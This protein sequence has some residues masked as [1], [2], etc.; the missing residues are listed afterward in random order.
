MS[1]RRPY[2]TE[3]I[4]SIKSQGLDP[5]EL[6]ITLTQSKAVQLA[7]VLLMIQLVITFSGDLKAHPP[8]TEQIIN[9]ES[10]LIELVKN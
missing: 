10:C 5:P 2:C 7:L 3:A 4:L 8:S 9:I 1:R 6:S